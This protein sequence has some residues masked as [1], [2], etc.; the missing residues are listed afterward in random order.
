MQA[1]HKIGVIL[2]KIK[3]EHSIV[4]LPV[5]FNRCDV[6]GIGLGSPLSGFLDQGRDLPWM[7]CMKLVVQLVQPSLW[8]CL[9]PSC[10]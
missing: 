6:S 4:A 2:E 1:L 9:K 10:R 5:R 7:F 3:W 8:P